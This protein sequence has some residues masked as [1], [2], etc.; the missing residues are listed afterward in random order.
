MKDIIE[1]RLNQA[2]G[3]LKAGNIKVSISWRGDSLSLQ[4]TLPPRPNSPK[5]YPHQQRIYLGI[6]ATIDGITQ[7]EKEARR[8]RA[9]LDAG[10]FVWDSPALREPSVEEWVSQFE[11]EYFARRQRKPQ[12]LTTWKGDYAKSFNKIQGDRL[13]PESIREAVLA[14]KPDS[15]NR[16][17]AVMALTALAKFAGI[18]INLQD[19][20]GK[21]SPR[22]VN[23]R[24]LP[25]DEQIAEWRERITNSAWQWFFG[26]VATYGLRP[27]EAFHIKRFDGHILEI[28]EDTKTGSRMI[29][30]YYPEWLE[31]WKLTEIVMPGVSGTTNSALGDRA[32]KYFRRNQ[33][34]FKL[35]DLRHCWARRTLQFGLDASLAAQQMGHSLQIHHN[36]YHCWIGKDIHSR[37]FYL[38]IESDNRPQ[39]PLPKP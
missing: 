26:V 29:W 34:P 17:R 19:L 14:T 30:P 6:P 24:N 22:R 36:I 33:L 2:N 31:A 23:P 8:L 5:Q 16:R 39:A 25:S 21:Y 20:S 18:E 11:K 35:Y 1:Q 12:S 28:G 15:R 7:A 3:R 4:A 10:A 27:H 9:K 37:A 13:T 32:A 38:A